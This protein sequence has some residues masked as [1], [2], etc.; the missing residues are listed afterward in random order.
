MAIQRRVILF[1][2]KKKQGSL[3]QQLN[4]L[5]EF[6]KFCIFREEHDISKFKVEWLYLFDHEI[7]Y[8]EFKKDK[9]S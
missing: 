4:N 3:P 8:N 9:S 5:Y 7:F 1:S 6:M 2:K